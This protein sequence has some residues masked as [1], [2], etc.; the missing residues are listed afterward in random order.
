MSIPHQW[1]TERTEM[2]A[3]GYQ[4]FIAAE[5]EVV[6][7]DCRESLVEGDYYQYD[8]YYLKDGGARRVV[9]GHCGAND[10]PDGEDDGGFANDGP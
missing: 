5:G 2:E 8:D 9:C 3:L 6:C 4:V 10:G 7:N 1:S